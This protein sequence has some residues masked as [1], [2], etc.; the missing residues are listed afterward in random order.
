VNAIGEMVPSDNL[1]SWVCSARCDAKSDAKSEL[2]AI[3]DAGNGGFLN[4]GGR[5][6]SATMNILWFLRDRNGSDHRA[7][8]SSDQ[9]GVVERRGVPFCSALMVG[10]KTRS[11]GAGKQS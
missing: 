5:G 3:L 11:P 1:H 10:A 2:P 6:W 4:W 7:F 8:A 9:R